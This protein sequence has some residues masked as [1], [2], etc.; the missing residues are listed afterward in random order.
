M[1]VALLQMPIQWNAPS[2]NMR[3]VEEAVLATNQEIDV[4]ILPEMFTTGFAVDPLT[5]NAD[6]GDALRWMVALAA[7]LDAAVAGSVMV[8]EDGR[9]YNRLYFV[10]PDGEIV[11]YDKRHLFAYGG[12]DQHYSSGTE[13]VVV[14]FRGVR[15]MLQV[16][17]DLRFPVWS[18]YTADSAYDAIIYVANWP[19]SRIAVWDTLTKARA[20]ENQCYVLAVNRI[21][22]DA[23][24]EYSGGTRVVSPYGKV[25][26]EARDGEEQLLVAELD[27]AR[28]HAFRHKFP[29]LLDRDDYTLYI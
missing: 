16:C 8:E 22:T 27:M 26:G 13:R 14:E 1:N 2:E 11:A 7:R 21:G 6:Q 5:A 4:L 9:F 24:C 23:A 29:V 18:R 12:E 25:L 17:Y 19:S 3:Y 20:I 28:L 10:K 15:F